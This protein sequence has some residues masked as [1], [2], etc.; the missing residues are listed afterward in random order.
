MKDGTS[1]SNAVLV[2]GLGN[3]RP[4]AKRKARATRPEGRIDAEAALLGMANSDSWAVR[5]ATA[6]AG[7][8]L[9]ALVVDDN[10]YVRQRAYAFLRRSSMTLVEWMEA[11]PG[12]V[13]D[14]H[15][16]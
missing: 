3:A 5:A 12:L 14:S 8:A 4:A 9:D 15:K 16:S 13:S 6:D 2:F 7:C 1:E 10:A 11:N